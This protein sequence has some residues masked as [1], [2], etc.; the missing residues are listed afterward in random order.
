MLHV[1]TL[2][3][4]GTNH[5]L[6][7]HRYMA[8]LGI[9]DYTVHFVDT[10]T[11]AVDDL[12][13]GRVDTIV[14]CAVHPETPR[15]L[16][17]NFRRIFAVDSFIA[18]SQELGILTRRDVEDPKTL[19]ILLPA[20]R[21]YTDVSRW[22]E[23]RNVGSLPTIAAMLLAGEIDAGL[24]YTSFA[25]RHPDVLRVDEVIGS[26][27]DVWIVYAQERVSTPGGLVGDPRSPGA[28]LLQRL[29]DPAR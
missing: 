11:T 26:P 28:R 19:G 8:T 18:D 16:G 27:D 21:D 15:V 29:A 23:L 4:T 6:V 10:F 1:A 20:N 5:E 24:T 25:A 13:A 3:P 9:E 7:V 12:V 17:E 2:G 14:Q 22:E